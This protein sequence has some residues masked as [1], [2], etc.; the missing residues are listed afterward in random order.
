MPRYLGIS[1]GLSTLLLAGCAEEAIDQSDLVY[2]AP[3]DDGDDIRVVDEAERLRMIDY[4]ET[5]VPADAIVTT[6]VNEAGEDV[7]CIDI[8]RQPGRVG[9]TE[10]LEYAPRTL[11][12]GMPSVDPTVPMDVPNAVCPRGTIPML[13]LDI[14]DLERF[15]TLEDFLSK[16]P[17]QV[18][19]DANGGPPS[20]DDDLELPRVGS[21]SSHQYAHATRT[22]DNYGTDAYF[23]IWA[24]YV[25]SSTEFSL[26]QMWVWRGSG[27][28]LETVEGGWQR[29]RGLYGDDSAH[30]FIF[31]TPNNYA[32]GCY[33]LTCAAFVQ[34]DGS[35]T[36]GGAQSPVSSAGG[37][38]YDIHLFWYRDTG[39]GNWWLQYQGVWV[40]YYPR[41]LFD[42]NGLYDKSSGVDVGGEI[43]NNN[44][45]R[46]TYTDMGGGY[47]PTSGYKY[48]AFIRNIRYVNTA[49]TY[50]NASSLTASRSDAY[51]Y[52]VTTA[53][54][55][56][57]SW[58]YYIY[59][60]GTGYNANC[61]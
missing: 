29:Y 40:G 60:G 30:L 19:G 9:A 48:A 44:S 22:V 34:T 58:K 8:D 5:L 32:S 25:E 16:V 4:L 14:T 45:G 15:E 36:I 56:S 24:P 21:T 38:Q 17:N 51:C 2:S 57:A 10:P 12:K 18:R 49:N 37:T 43:V 27:A 7:D 11:P 52:E 53:Y 35:V 54:S 23:N 46:H 28:N 13:H 42:A 39:T 26:S 20:A 1:L 47:F 6:A 31:Y 55:A 61:T 3:S 33:N 50:Q 41:S 59:F